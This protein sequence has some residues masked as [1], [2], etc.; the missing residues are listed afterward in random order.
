MSDHEF[1]LGVLYG[2]FIAGVQFAALALLGMP[3]WSLSAGLVAT[4]AI[5]TFELWSERP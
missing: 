1:K 3:L 4:A 2:T 5:W